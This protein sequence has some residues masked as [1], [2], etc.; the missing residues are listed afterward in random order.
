MN[1]N[2]NIPAPETKEVMS[3]KKFI[4]I[5]NNIIMSKTIKIT[6]KHRD[7]QMMNWLK[8]SK[9]LYIE[10]TRRVFNEAKAKSK[11]ITGEFNE[12]KLKF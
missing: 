2:N 3:Y 6:A 5:S 10:Y 12:S 11:Y 4:E 7:T 8:I 9:E 1:T